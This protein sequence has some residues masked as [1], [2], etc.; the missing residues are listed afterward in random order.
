M[1]RIIVFFVV[2]CICIVTN[3][4]IRPLFIRIS[5]SILHL[6]CVRHF[7]RVLYVHLLLSSSILL[8]ECFVLFT[9]VTLTTFFSKS[10]VVDF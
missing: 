1:V 7:I 8:I 3:D 5:L 2:V 10:L 6:G 9:P 4:I